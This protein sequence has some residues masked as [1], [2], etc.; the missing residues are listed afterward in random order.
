M[1]FFTWCKFS[2]KKIQYAKGTSLGGDDGIA[3]AYALAL[4]SSN[5]I[6]HPALE[7]VITVDEEVGMEGAN[8]IDASLLNGKILLNEDLE[9]RVVYEINRF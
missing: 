3:V 8:A 5:D 9:I 1:C 6:P 2:F 7:V 4:L